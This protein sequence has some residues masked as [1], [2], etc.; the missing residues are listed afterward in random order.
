MRKKELVASIR[1]LECKVETLLN[2]Q[3]QINTQILTDRREI[4]QFNIL[5][6]PVCKYL[7]PDPTLKGKVDAIA[8]HLNLSFEV[9]REKV[10][11]SKVVAKKGKK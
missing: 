6:Y 1:E 10:E 3:K 5:G 7:R 9:T 4:P 8:E 2:A 11:P